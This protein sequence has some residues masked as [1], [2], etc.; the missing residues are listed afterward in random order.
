MKRLIVLSLLGLW[1]AIVCAEDEAMR[2]ATVLAAE[3][4]C[5]LSYNGGAIEA[6]IEANVP[7]DDLDFA[8]DL[9]MYISV[10]E[11]EWRSIETSEKLAQCAQTR[12]VAKSFGFL[13]QE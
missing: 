2:L 1:P 7:G 3:K 8:G 5:S 11:F 10:R 13:K 6:W 4:P 9:R 12:R